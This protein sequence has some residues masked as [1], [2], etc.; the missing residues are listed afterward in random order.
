MQKYPTAFH[1]VQRWF[2]GVLHLWASLHGVVTPYNNCTFSHGTHGHTDTQR[3]RCK[4]Q[5]Q[6]TLALTSKE[7]PTPFH[8]QPNFFLSQLSFSKGEVQLYQRATAT[9]VVFKGSKKEG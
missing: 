7:T 5:S 9:N 3:H 8:H 4:V 1:F 6:S 2:S